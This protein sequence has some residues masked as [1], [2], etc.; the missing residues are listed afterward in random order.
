[1]YKIY[2]IFLYYVVLQNSI[3]KLLKINKNITGFTFILSVKYLIFIYLDQPPKV[4]KKF[5]FLPQEYYYSISELLI[6]VDKKII[7]IEILNIAN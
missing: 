1:M 3:Y 4:Q 7:S 2:H 5:Y 6:S